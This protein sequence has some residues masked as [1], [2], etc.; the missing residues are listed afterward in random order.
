ML[1]AVLIS[2]MMAQFALEN[3]PAVVSARTDDIH[4]LLPF[5]SD[6]ADPECRGVWIKTH[7]PWVAKAPCENLR[8]CAGY[9]YQGL[10]GGTL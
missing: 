4:F 1:G 7:A 9:A 10:S 3:A 6:I 5:S 2:V 8:H